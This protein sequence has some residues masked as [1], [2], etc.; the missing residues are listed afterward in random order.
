LIIFIYLDELP[1]PILTY[2]HYDIFVAHGSKSFGTRI[3]SL[4]YNTNF[5]IENEADLIAELHNILAKLSA[6]H[7]TVLCLLLA[8]LNESGG[9]KLGLSIALGPVLLKSGNPS[10]TNDES[11]ACSLVVIRL[12]AHQEKLFSGAKE[13]KD[14]PFFLTRKRANTNNLIIGAVA[15]KILIKNH[16]NRPKKADPVDESIGYLD[17]KKKFT[18]FFLISCRATPPSQRSGVMFP[19]KISSLII[20][21]RPASTNEISMNGMYHIFGHNFL[22]KFMYSLQ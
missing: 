22:T 9:D 18:F 1:V 11:K 13:G 12:I 7:R 21:D 8:Y 6:A 2:E 5:S 14:I 4:F 3:I 16:A 19:R 17:S 20:P 15:R 10:K